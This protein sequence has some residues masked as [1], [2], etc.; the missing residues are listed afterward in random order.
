[1]GG[2]PL[3][4][5]G[6]PVFVWFLDLDD[7]GNTPVHAWYTLLPNGGH[8]VALC[9]RIALDI[10]RLGP[11]GNAL[12]CPACRDVTALIAPPI[13]SAKGPA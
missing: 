11:P 1:M 13:D 4:D 9:G 6:M 10:D 12:R 5:L 2:A 8:V 3:A 7:D